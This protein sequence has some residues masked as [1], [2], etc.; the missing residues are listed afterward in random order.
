LLAQLLPSN[1][2]HLCALVRLVEQSGQREVIILGLYFKANT[3]DLRESAL[4]EVAQLLRGRGYRLRIY[5]PQLN[6]ARLIGRN[7]RAIEAKIPGLARLLH[8]D[9]GKALGKRGLVLV[10][11]KCATIPELRRH[12]GAKHRL[13]D[14]NHWPELRQLPCAYEG[15]CW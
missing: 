2:Q 4:V 9:L 3:D 10:A 15:F 7:K 11:Q 1:A 8:S 12:L 5:D 13:L 14:V 6:L